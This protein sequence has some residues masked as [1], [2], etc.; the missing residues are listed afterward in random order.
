[1][2]FVKC[3]HCGEWHEVQPGDIRDVPPLEVILQAETLLPVAV[4]IV[5]NRDSL[6]PGFLRG[7]PVALRVLGD[8]LGYGHSQV[9]VGLLELQRLGMI[10]SV[11]FGKRRHRYA[12]TRQLTRAKLA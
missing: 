2:P 1:M 8:T 7:D 12:G 5:Q 11:P 10:K 4:S 9:R 3:P 6:P